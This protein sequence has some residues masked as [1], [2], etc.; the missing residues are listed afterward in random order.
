MAD[1]IEEFFARAALIQS[2]IHADKEP[3]EAAFDNFDDL[4]KWLNDE[5]P[6]PSANRTS[7][8]TGGGA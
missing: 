1:E 4:M 5:P 2:I 3:P 8:E 6:I 7:E